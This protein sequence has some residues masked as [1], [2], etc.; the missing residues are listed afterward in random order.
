MNQKGHLIK[1]AD[2]LFEKVE[3][4]LEREGPLKMQS[5]SFL[6]CIRLNTPPKV[7]AELGKEALKIAL[8]VEKEIH[9]YFPVAS[10]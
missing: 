6:S 1:T 4:S 9:A 3:I 8:I 5:V 10:N 7:D 2:K